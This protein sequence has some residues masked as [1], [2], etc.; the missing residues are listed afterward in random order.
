MR[1]SVMPHSLQKVLTAIAT[2]WQRFKDSFE[3]DSC[4]KE[5]ERI[6]SD[7]GLSAVELRRLTARGPDAANEL[8]ER[9]AAFQLAHAASDDP[10]ILRDL[11]RVCSQCDAKRRCRSDLKRGLSS[12]DDEYCPNHQTLVALAQLSLARKPN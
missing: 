11:D 4:G 5:V 3:L 10:V 12:I 6:A 2:R 9:L 7:L 1:E 8:H